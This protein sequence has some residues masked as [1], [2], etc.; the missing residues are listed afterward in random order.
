MAFP[1]VPKA[2]IVNVISKE[3]CE[4]VTFGIVI[5][6]ATPNSAKPDF[7]RNVKVL[8]LLAPKSPDT[9]TAKE[10]PTENPFV[11]TLNVPTPGPIIL[12]SDVVPDTV[13]LFPV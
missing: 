3:K 1:A 2:L 9:L 6:P 11:G 7:T 10:S 5:G 13:I 4:D 12:N 8:P